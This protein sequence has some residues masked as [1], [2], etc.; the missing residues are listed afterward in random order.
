MTEVVIVEDDV[1][2]DDEGRPWSYMTATDHRVADDPGCT[3]VSPIP[4]S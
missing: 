4:N 2:S 3:T 1:N